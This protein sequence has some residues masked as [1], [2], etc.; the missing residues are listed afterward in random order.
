MSPGLRDDFLHH[1]VL[2]RTRNAGGQ[3]TAPV[4]TARGPFYD[5]SLNPSPSLANMSTTLVELQHVTRSVPNRDPPLVD[6]VSISI[7]AGDQIGLTGPSGSGKSTLLRCLARL[8]PVT[9]GQLRFQSNVVTADALPRYR[10]Q[11]IYLHQRPA[12]LL[13]TVRD[14]LRLPFT[15]E[16]SDSSYNETCHENWLDALGRSRSILDQSIETLS[17]GEQQVVALMRAIQIDPLVLLLDEPTASLDPEATQRF[18]QLVRLWHS[19]SAQRA[20]VWISHDPSQLHRMTNRS[21]QMMDGRIIDPPV[22]DEQ[23]VDGRRNP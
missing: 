20:Y 18:E 16:S 8:D 13:G 5:T 12:M 15:L 19:E 6:D 9:V 21:W 11:V 10:R 1:P 22:L 7:V 23:P 2:I 3:H 17:G 14:N 4:V